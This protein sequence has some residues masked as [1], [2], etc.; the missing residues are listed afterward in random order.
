MLLGDLSALLAILSFFAFRREV[1]TETR[2][3]FLI[4]CFLFLLHG[5]LLG[6]FLLSKRW[7]LPLDE[8]A[9][10]YA[11]QYRLLIYFL[12][13]PGCVICLVVGLSSVKLRNSLKYIL[14]LIVVGGVWGYV[15]F[16]YFANP[17]Y[18]YTTPDIRDYSAIRGA[19]EDLQRRGVANPNSGQIASELLRHPRENSH[20]GGRIST[21]LGEARVLEILPYFRGDDVSL[22]VYRPLWRSCFAIASLTIGS[23]LLFFLYQ[24]LAD[25]PKRAYMEKV[26]WCLLPFC[27]FEALHYYAFVQVNQFEGFRAVASLG[28]YASMGAMLA[29]LLLLLLRLRF[30]QTIEG[31]FYEDRLMRDATHITRW[32]DAFDNWVLRQFANPMELDRRFLVHSR[33]TSAEDE[34]KKG[35]NNVT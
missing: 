34:A 1:V 18:L 29:L 3:F 17:K 33:F 16:P 15:S 24:Y 26:L 35:R 22:L 30:I 19:I 25:P 9:E 2:I 5:L 21:K 7:L 20:L 31:R 32:R 14:A 13:L 10:F 8:W 12:L 23:I 4:L 27:C 11:Y 28:E 6:L